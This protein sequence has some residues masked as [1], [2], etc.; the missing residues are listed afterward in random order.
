MRAGA[1]GVV[2][3]RGR[4]SIV[5]G[6]LC[7]ALPSGTASAW[8]FSEHTRITQRALE[9]LARDHRELSDA[10]LVLAARELHLCA[11]KTCPSGQIPL[12]A[13]PSFAGDHSCKPAELRRML[14]ERDGA[15]VWIRG[16][17]AVSEQTDRALRAAGRDAD[18]RADIRRRMHVD[19]QGVDAR[20]VKRALIDSSH[21]QIARE[22]SDPVELQA[23]LKLV[24]PGY[25][26]ANATAA[27][28]NYHLVALRHAARAR[29]ES[30]DRELAR[31]LYYELF[32]LHFL[33]DSFASG[34]FVGHW[35]DEAT[36]MGT[37]DYYAR[38][39]I[40]TARWGSP[41]QSY[42]A[43]G[44]AFLTDAEL[45][46]AAQAVEASLIQLLDPPQ[47]DAVLLAAH[48]VF[49]FADYDSCTDPLVPPGLIEL[50]S[51]E[52]RVHV[53]AVLDSQPIPTLRDP[54][55]PRVR[56]ENGFFVGGAATTGYALMWATG[57]T[58]QFDASLRLGYGAAGIVDDPLNAQAFADI[59]FAG[60]YLLGANQPGVVGYNLRLRAPGYFVLL[61]GMLAIALGQAF[62]ADCPFCIDWAAAA[63]GGGA[64]RL[65]K[66][67]TVAG[68]V[69]G[70]LS[71]LRDVT[72]RVFPSSAAE[73]NY[74]TEVLLPVLTFRNVLP[75][76][77]DGIAQSTDVYL[78]MG[79]SL[80]WSGEHPQL[81][82]GGFL[83]LSAA[84]RVFP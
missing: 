8:V 77:G 57:H 68:A 18:A 5:L 46:V 19:M 81:A 6:L 14:E 71:A 83:S 15:A 3:R 76:S 58:F 33:E 48:A 43:H 60:G 70:Q 80:T 49:G 59:G 26:E 74:R 67:F 38:H 42:I 45:E 23:Y 56:L 24:L 16:V 73:P 84:T 39:G 53:R 17:L 34:H 65:W 28:L 4:A 55:I 75:I 52:A 29:R 50:A 36:R 79:A 61:D 11:A 10:F 47:T 66:S 2:V 54:S 22:F 41:Q 1:I 69:T 63:A 82:P 21:F 62:K 64:G 31:A 51:S 44:D 40:A 32:A 20:Y 72:L 30:D 13:V 7:L 9:L 78:D 35:G 25:R 12:A 37:H 27:Y